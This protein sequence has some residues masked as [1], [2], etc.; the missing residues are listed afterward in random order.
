MKRKDTDFI[1]KALHEAK[2]RDDSHLKGWLCAVWG[3]SKA[4]LEEDCNFDHARF[5][6]IA[7][8]GIVRGTI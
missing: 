5:R 6:S 4:L 2:P 8:N 1:A 7:E 3:V